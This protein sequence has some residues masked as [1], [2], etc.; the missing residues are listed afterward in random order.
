MLVRVSLISSA[1]PVG[2]AAGADGFEEFPPA[3][4]DGVAA[5]FDEVFRGGAVEPV[6]GIL[7]SS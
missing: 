7:F 6:F 4:V 2:A 1:L 5:V 3:L